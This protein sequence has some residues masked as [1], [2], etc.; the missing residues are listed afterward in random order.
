MILQEI[1]LQNFRSYTKKTFAFSPE[2]TLIVGPNGAGKTNILE[3]IMYLATGRSFRAGEDREVVH[4]GKDVCFA[5]AAIG[6]TTL[7]IVITTGSIE[8]QDVPRKRYKVNDVPRRLVDFIGNLRAVLFWPEHLELVTDSPSLRRRYLDSVLVQV[9]REYRRNLLSYERGL[10]QRNKLLDAINVGTAVPSQLLFW[11]QLLIKA[12]GYIT[13]KRGEY[14][15]YINSCQLSP[16][17][18]SGQAAISYQLKYDK[19][20]ISESRLEQYKEEEVA[21]GATLVG[22]HR[23][24]FVVF[25]SQISNHNDQINAKQLSKYGSRGEQ[26]L[27]VLWLKLAE[28]SYIEKE[29]GE[30]PILLLDD[31]FS[32]LDGAHRELVVEL[33]GRQQTILTSADEASIP[34]AVLESATVIR[35]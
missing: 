4:W 11:D 9:D 13:D 5:S 30:R 27:A 32:E 26:R 33:I 10:R 18:D 19:S 31:I 29:V 21:A 28:L 20:V 8:G 25:K 23:D 24:D 2:T 12:G 1:A 16:R 7:E 6:D 34:A 22:P 17:E 14:I 35:L 15:D 3:A